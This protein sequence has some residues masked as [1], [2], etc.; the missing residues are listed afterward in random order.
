MNSKSEDFG[1]VLKFCAS[2]GTS[3]SRINRKFSIS[4]GEI[5][6][7]SVTIKLVWLN[8]KIIFNFKF[9]FEFRSTGPENSKKKQ[10]LH[11]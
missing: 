4:S 11:F 5:L 2:L 10:K 3:R 8:K 1:I 6:S 7:T 9:I